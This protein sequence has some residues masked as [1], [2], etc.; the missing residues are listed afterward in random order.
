MSILDL[1]DFDNG[2]M[3]KEVEYLNLLHDTFLGTT[4]TAFVVNR[5]IPI[6]H[7]G[8]VLGIRSKYID[9]SQTSKGDYNRFAQHLNQFKYDG[10]MIDNVD[11]IPDNSDREDWEEFVR[12]ALKR[13]TDY[14]LLPFGD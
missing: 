1:S 9:L 10:L 11:E 3:D 7:V 2:T 5:D 13:E 14:Q 12:F 4:L 8:K 6:N